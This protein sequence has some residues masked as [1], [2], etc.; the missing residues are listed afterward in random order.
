MLLANAVTF[1][2]HGLTMAAGGSFEPPSIDEFFPPDVLFAGT[3]F[4]LN[5]ILL[6]RL[7]MT[8]VL[9]V[10]FW[11][12]AS[13]MKIV[14]GR[15]Q[16]AMEWI[17]QF[18]RVQIV[19]ETMGKELAQRFFPLL[20]AIFFS[21]LFWN[22]T[23]IIPGLQIASTALIGV[24]FVLGM[25]AYIAF[26]YAGIKQH[27][28]WHY[29]YKELFPEGVPKPLYILITPIEFVSTFIL[30]PLILAVRLTMNMF[31]GHILLVLCFTATSFFLLNMGGLWKAMSGGM[32]V[33]GFVFTLFELL[34][35][36]LQTYIFTLLTASYI[37][38]AS[39]EG[40]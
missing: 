14:P 17:L 10:I 32:L 8:I 40:H 21:I 39:A 11:L 1:M 13:R 24:T 29:L 26:I 7:L 18:V 27:G 23:G 20:A 28:G 12:F 19:E 35:I 6:I 22:I 9:L 4:A 2:S 3:P 30:R 37:Q 33:L 34:I 38:M 36:V 5:R 16:A 15:A 31:V 25:T